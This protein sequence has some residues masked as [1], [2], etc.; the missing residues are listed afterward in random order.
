M[1]TRDARR[2]EQKFEHRTL[3]F[4]REVWVGDKK[5]KVIGIKTTFSSK[6]LYRIG[7]TVNVDGV[8]D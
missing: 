7:D 3:K 5:L 6:R 1:F 4:T 8:E 2:N